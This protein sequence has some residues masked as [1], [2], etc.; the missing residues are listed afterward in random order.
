MFHTYMK[1]GKNYNLLY[2]KLGFG[3]GGVY[4]LCTLHRHT[5]LD[6]QYTHFP[7]GLYSLLQISLYLLVHLY[8][9]IS[10]SMDISTFLSYQ[11]VFISILYLLTL[12]LVSQHVLTYFCDTSDLP[13]PFASFH[14]MSFQFRKKSPLFPTL[15]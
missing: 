2:F 7:L 13:C 11:S 4:W 10:S 9:P 14:L 12:L 3:G 15:V 8:S 5:F 1:Y 6:C